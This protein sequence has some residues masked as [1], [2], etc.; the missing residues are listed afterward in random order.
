MMM[1]FVC[2]ILQSLTHSIFRSNLGPN[3]L[4]FVF[5]IVKLTS[6]ILY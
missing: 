5:Y 2:T 1:T 6:V 3:V 4:I